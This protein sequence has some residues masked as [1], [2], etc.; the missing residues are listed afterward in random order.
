MREAAGQI[1]GL[2]EVAAGLL[3][4]DGE[5]DDC[6]GVVG[7]HKNLSITLWQ[8]WPDHLVQHTTRKGALAE[9]PSSRMTYLQKEG[10]KLV[11]WM[12]DRNLS[13]A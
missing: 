6:L 5:L 12:L 3:D 9:I 2:L 1:R 8:C 4:T 7:G 11:F 13:R 10:Q